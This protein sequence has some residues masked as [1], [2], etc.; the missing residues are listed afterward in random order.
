V[1]TGIGHVAPVS[2]AL[3]GWNPEETLRWLEAYQVR[4]GLLVYARVDLVWDDVRSDPR[5]RD[6]V[7]RI[8]VPP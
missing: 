8:G 3:S 7:K 4:T 6:L 5:F 1:G 2:L